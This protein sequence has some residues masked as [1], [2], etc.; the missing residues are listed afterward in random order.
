[1]IYLV[2]GNDNKKKNSF[3]KTIYEKEKPII[4][5]KEEASR[6]L[7]LS[8]AESRSLFGDKK[9]FLMEDFIKEGVVSFSKEEL[10]ILEK[11][12]NVFVFLE[13]KIKVA[14]LKIYKNFSQINTF[15]LKTTAKPF[16]INVFD[17]AELFARKNK[18]GAWINYRKAIDLGIEPEE[19]SGILLWKIRTMAMNR[20]SLFT[21]EE[22]SNYFNQITDIY[23][24]AHLGKID[25]VLGLEHFILSSLSK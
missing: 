10:S 8:Y 14:D 16:K 13:D 11:V 19:I 7:I 25:M 12:D 15:N 6:E 20:N 24:L 22:L 9:I 2:E 21:K 23:H 17:I 18:I 4:I 3:L 1:M 5:S